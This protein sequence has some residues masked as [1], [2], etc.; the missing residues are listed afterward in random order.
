[1]IHSP[2][3]RDFLAHNAALIATGFGTGLAAAESE[4]K[5][6]DEP[7]PIID[8][9][10]HLWDL[11]QF[12]LPWIKEG[13]PLARNF[14]MSDYFKA[15]EGLN[16]VKTIYMEVDLD[17]KQQ[18]Q[19]A[20]FVVATCRRADN[21]MVAGVVSGRPGSSTFPKYI[22]QYKNSAYIKGVRQ[23][24]HNEGIPAG[25]CLDEMFIR[26]IRLL[27][28][29]DKSF[30]LCMRPGELL[31]A[32]KLIDACPDTR[33]I[34]DH[35]GNA[36]VPDKDRTQWKK[37]MDAVAKRK[38]VVC[39]VS[40]IV[41]SA[42]KGKWAAEDLAPIVNHTLDAFGPDRV[43]F[44]GDWPVCLLGAT[45]REWVET[46]RQIVRDHKPEEQRK[47]FYDNAV[48]VYGLA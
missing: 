14:L 44:G 28:Q 2:T 5:S 10:Q 13:M 25:T 48:R 46:L 29:L 41:A 42:E 26:G 24:L 35:C 6:M 11:K 9:H 16:V 36:K 22:E 31:D 43:M 12:K 30:D 15:T 20:E 21:P 40:G 19:E 27:G 39:K 18:Q 45:Y 38:N 47:L 32:A 3:R 4:A 37:G 8:T 7:L 23:V 17:P 1:M 34:L 33:F